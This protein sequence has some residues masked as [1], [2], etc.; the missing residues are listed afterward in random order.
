MGRMWSKAG[1][2]G[3]MAWGLC[4]PSTVHQR[5]TTTTSRA[6]PMPEAVPARSVIEISWLPHRWHP[7][8]PE[9]TKS[10]FIDKA[11]RIAVIR[12]SCAL[13]YPLT[14]LRTTNNHSIPDILYLWESKF[15]G[16]QLRSTAS[17]YHLV[18]L[19]HETCSREFERDEVRPG[20]IGLRG[21]SP[22]NSDKDLL[23]GSAISFAYRSQCCEPKL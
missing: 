12:P 16:W 3:I 21:V 20:V 4:M 14:F 17:S 8:L 18:P 7:G 1:L 10:G 23:R 22:R 11:V 5:H 2:I 6:R 13:R 15:Q 19:T 9:S